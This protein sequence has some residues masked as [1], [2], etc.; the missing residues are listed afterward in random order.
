MIP[1]A[2][3]KTAIPPTTPPMR[4]PLFF[5]E[6][7]GGGGGARSSVKRRAPMRTS[8]AVVWFPGERSVCEFAGPVQLPE[9]I[10]LPGV[11]ARSRT[12]LYCL[13]VG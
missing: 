5:F 9:Y 6:V 2:T 12:A 4:G 7:G 10:L 8:N 11:V 3:A 1:T 13:G